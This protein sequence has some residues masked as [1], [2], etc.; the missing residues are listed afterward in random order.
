MNYPKRDCIIILSKIPKMER[1]INFKVKF[2]EP[3]CTLILS[4]VLQGNKDNRIIEYM[5]RSPQYH[6][7]QSPVKTSSLQ[8]RLP[9]NH[10]LL[11]AAFFLTNGSFLVTVE[12][13]C[14]E[15]ASFAS[16]LTILAFLLTV[17]VSFS[18]NWSFFACSG[19]VRLLRALRDIKQRG[20]TVSKKLQP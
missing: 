6:M 12:L 5:L 19:K 10:Y 2:P 7:P 15:L 8:N 3:G 18:Y 16:L 9:E 4:K 14:L 11:D 13:F 1:I 17:L 20:L